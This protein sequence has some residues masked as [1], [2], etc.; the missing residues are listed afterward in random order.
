MNGSIICTPGVAEGV[1]KWLSSPKDK[2]SLSETCRTM[3]KVFL[4]LYFPTNILRPI[5]L[6]ISCQSSPA[7]KCSGDGCSKSPCG[8]IMGISGKEFGKISTI[9]HCHR[10]NCRIGIIK[11]SYH[12]LVRLLLIDNGNG[13][14][15]DPS[16][17]YYL[18]KR[19]CSKSSSIGIKHDIIVSN[20]I[21]R[22]ISSDRTFDVNTESACPS[23]EELKMSTSTSWVSETHV[24]D[25]INS[26]VLYVSF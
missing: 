7:K 18:L 22:L 20:M 5:Q 9:S 13:F 19:C 24:E 2:K 25:C 11:K 4:S 12:N 8:T 15:V 21:K 14:Y 23:F 26:T 3:R 1:F 6:S 17:Y 16:D 10:A